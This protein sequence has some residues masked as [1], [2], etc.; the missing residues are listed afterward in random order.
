LP[1]PWRGA[2]IAEGARAREGKNAPHPSTDLGA[3]GDSR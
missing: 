3:G 2:R 1:A